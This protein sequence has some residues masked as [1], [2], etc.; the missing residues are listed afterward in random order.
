MP[1]ESKMDACDE[2]TSILRLRIVV[3]RPIEN[4]VAFYA[5]A[6]MFGK[7]NGLWG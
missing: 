5:V 1:E 3:W 2:V 7:D 4:D 6:Y